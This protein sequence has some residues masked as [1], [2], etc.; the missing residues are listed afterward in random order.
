MKILAVDFGVRRLGFAVGNSLTRTA[1]PL[2]QLVRGGD[3]AV[4]H[5]IRQLIETYEIERVIV[6]RPRHMDGARSATTTL[7][8]QFIG[9]LRKRVSVPVEAVD[10][11]LTSFDAEE[12]LREVEPDPR[13]RKALLD[14]VSAQV[15]AE[16][17]LSES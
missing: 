15:M 12:R 9:Y 10:E 14:S 1:V 6:G 3:E 13:R 16:M 8:E 7:A 5:H 4:L 2:P 17:Y 11:R